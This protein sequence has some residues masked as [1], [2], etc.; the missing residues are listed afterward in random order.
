VKEVA[1][2]KPFYAV[3]LGIYLAGDMKSEPIFDLF[4]AKAKKE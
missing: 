3:L 2:Q 4:Y 1:L